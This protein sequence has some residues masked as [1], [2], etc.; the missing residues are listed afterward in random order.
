[1]YSILKDLNLGKWVKKR[2][3]SKYFSSL[4]SDIISQQLSDKAA[5]TIY[6]RFVKVLPNKKVTPDTVL[7][8]S[9]GRLRKA[10]MSWAKASYLRNLAVAT[11]KG[12]LKLNALPKF[13]DEQVIRELVKVKGIGDWTAEMFLIFSLGREDVYSHGDQGLRTAII[14]LYNLRIPTRARID[15]I[16]NKWKPYRSYGCIAL[17]HSLDTAK[18]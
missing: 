13:P 1:M 17:W 6:N 4:C 11:K 7:N 15:R 9:D 2:P 14:K 10:G 18:K 3:K 12:E 8:L 16:V 5:T